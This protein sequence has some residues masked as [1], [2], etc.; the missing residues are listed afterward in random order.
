MHHGKLEATPR[1][2]VKVNIQPPHARVSLHL[3]DARMQP[4]AKAVRWSPLAILHRA[5]LPSNGALGVQSSGRSS[6]KWVPARPVEAS[7]ESLPKPTASTF[8]RQVAPSTDGECVWVLVF[9]T[10]KHL[11]TI[12]R[13]GALDMTQAADGSPS[14]GTCLEETAWCCCCCQ[15][16]FSQLPKTGLGNIRNKRAPTSCNTQKQHLYAPEA[17]HQR[18]AQLPTSPSFISFTV[19]APRQSTGIGPG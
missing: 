4:R 9:V 19:V 7:A 11:Q 14:P 17:Q 12:S 13:R 8:H 15:G 18:Q 3:G 2:D 16:K 5:A 6:R 10:G 1:D